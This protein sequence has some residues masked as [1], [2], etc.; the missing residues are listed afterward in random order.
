MNMVLVVVLLLAFWGLSFY[1]RSHPGHPL[2]LLLPSAAG[3]FFLVNAALNP[4]QR[5]FSLFLV[6]LAAGAAWRA[7]QVRKARHGAHS[8][9]VG[10]AG[11]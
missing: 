10:S 2:S 5:Y 1:W 7:H 8:L 3:L 4:E 6:M 11:R 9:R